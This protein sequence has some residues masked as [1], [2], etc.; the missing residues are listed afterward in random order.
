MAF[1]PQPQEEVGAD[2]DTNIDVHTTNGTPI[3][4]LPLDHLYSATSSCR[5]NPSGSSNVMSKKVKARK[6][7]LTHL[8]DSDQKK[9]LGKPPLVH[10]YS[11]RR[12]RPRYSEKGLSAYDSLV[13]RA[14]SNLEIHEIG[15]SVKE[16]EDENSEAGRLLKKMR[17]G[18]S[19][20]EKLGADLDAL[21]GSSTDRTR[22][23]NF[24][25]HD[26]NIRNISNARKRKDIS[27]EDSQKNHCLQRTM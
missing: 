5:V 26:F 23:R 18:N 10:V 11:R 12:K 3:R 22:L 14:E 19:E 24:R 8:D 21:G 4:Y 25:N 2:D 20:L 6:F 1:L 9:Q 16:L 13:A 17:G 15:D 7:S 27:S